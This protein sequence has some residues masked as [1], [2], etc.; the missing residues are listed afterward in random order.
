[1]AAG[2]IR[3]PQFCGGKA[4]GALGSR[5]SRTF[6]ASRITGLTQV[7]NTFEFSG[8]AC[9]TAGSVGASGTRG[10]ARN[11][12]EARN[13]LVG[14]IAHEAGCGVAGGAVTSAAGAYWVN[15]PDDTGGATGVPCSRAGS[16]QIVALLAGASDE[17]M[18]DIAGQT[19][20]SVV[21]VA[22]GAVC[23]SAGAGVRAI[24]V[25]CGAAQAG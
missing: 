6:L 2:V 11:T 12:G 15:G 1:M 25:S 10:M 7:E 8:R 20:G 16:A 5:R 22:A 19:D 18:S 3:R 21:R 13:V 4:N 9:E 23:G 14:G 17:V 24:G